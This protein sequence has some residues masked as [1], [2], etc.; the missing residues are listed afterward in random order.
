MT[1]NKNSQELVAKYRQEKTDFLDS[2]QPDDFRNGSSFNQV[3]TIIDELNEGAY[4]AALDKKDPQEFI[5]KA[6]TH[7][8]RE[9]SPMAEKLLELAR[10]YLKMKR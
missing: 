5:K 2:L 8:F 9:D 4:H 7:L 3:E 6:A 10:S 1:K